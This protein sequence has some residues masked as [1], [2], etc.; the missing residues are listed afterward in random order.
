MSIEIVPISQQFTKYYTGRGFELLPRASMLDPSIPMSFVMSAGLVQIE[1]SLAQASM[2]SGNQFVL[3]QSCFRHFDLESVGRDGTHLSF[4]EM[5]GAFTFGPNN[6]LET[7]QRVWFLATAV[8]GIDQDRIWVTYFKGGSI[9]QNSLAEDVETRKIWQSLGIPSERIIGLAGNYWIQG[10]GIVN[11]PTPRK[12]GPNTEMFFDLG[13]DKNCGADCAPGCN[14]GR[15]IEFSNSLFI[16]YEMEKEN[17]ALSPIPEP[18]TETV[19]G[20]E[21]VSMILQEVSSVFDIERFKPVINLI[22]Q[23]TDKDDLP[24]AIISVGE[25]VIADHIRALYYLIA[26]GAPPPGKNGRERIIKLLIRRVLAH[27]YILG[28]D[29]STFLSNLLDC[30]SSTSVL[31]LDGLGAKLRVLQYFDMEQVK[32]TETIQRGRQ[33]LNKLLVE[34]QG[35]TLSG[36]QIAELEK[37][38]GLPQSLIEVLLWEKGLSFLKAE[39][40]QAIHLW[41]RTALN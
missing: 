19:F 21:R 33:Y 28:I 37:K 5:P 9:F 25:R 20:T 15:F 7:I 11:M 10:R 30:V 1:T 18:F 38:Q 32:F 14:C 27:M 4:F 23:F 29:S 6:K 39:Y 12:C 41:K 13:V 31:T 40:K 24:T 36:V 35:G 16:G 22:R 8:L 17:N 2:R 26:D 34:N 3:V